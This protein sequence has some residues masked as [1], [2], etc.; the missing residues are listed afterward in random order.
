M[1][2]KER[3]NEAKENVSHYLKEGI[4]KKLTIKEPSVGKI[5]INN[6]N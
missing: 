2:S 4:L 6:C 5:L 1:L 3:I